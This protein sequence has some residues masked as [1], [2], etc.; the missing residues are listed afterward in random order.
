VN[1]R[2][3]ASEAARRWYLARAPQVLVQ[4]TAKVLARG[5]S[6]RLE[7]GWHFDNGADDSRQL[8]QFRR[9]IWNYY[10]DRGLTAPVT[11][12]WY[13]GLK[14]KLFLGNDMS[15]CLFAGGSFEPN[16]FVFLQAVLKPGMVFFD[17][18]ANDG[19]YSLYA[20]RRVGPDGVVMAVEPSGR[21]YERLKANLELNRLADIRTLRVALGKERGSGTLAI[22]EEGHE[23]QNTLGVR[24]SNPTVETTRHEAVSIETID[25]LVSREG[26]QRLDFL[27]LDV[28][29]SEVDALE[30]ARSTIARFRPLMLLEAEDE[31]LASQSRTKDDLVRLVTELAYELWVFDRESGQLRPVRGPNELEGNVIAG[32]ADWVPPVL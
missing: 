24:V 23:G 22:A 20:S 12:R 29:G 11:F 13:E 32:S 4:A 27:K 9:D 26:L 30:G 21:E 14:V 31:R 8:T 6:L 15:L 18:G 7:P 28:E 10:G 1:L 3:A 16:E 19:L 5:R 2:V 17:G 25:E